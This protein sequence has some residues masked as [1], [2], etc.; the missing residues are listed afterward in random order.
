MPLSAACGC[1]LC[2]IEARLLSEVSRIEA[3]T[4]CALFSGCENLQGRYS[5]KNLLSRLRASPDG[6][7]S[8]EVLSQL[9]LSR[10][11]QPALV[12]SVLILAFLP[13]LHATVRR[14]AKHQPRLL[15]EDI[16]QQSLAFLMQYL[17]STEFLSRRSHFAF[18]ISRAVKRQM[19]EWA[20]R[21]SAREAVFCHSRGG[22]VPDSAVASFERQALLRHFLHGCV[23]KGLLAN[24]ELD[25]LIE[26]KLNGT[27]GKEF[28]DFNGTSSNAVRQK[29]KRLLAKLRRLA[30]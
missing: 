9:F 15:E 26:F 22:T 19:F 13:V 3:G 28:A 20:K 1:A 5:A 6:A 12:E 16:A 17:R 8:D 30:R 18:G 14:V 21:E 4:G 24:G 25:L 27:N 7:S 23:T 29:L 2:E 11:A 10:R